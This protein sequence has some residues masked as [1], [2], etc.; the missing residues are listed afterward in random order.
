MI[1]AFGS[2]SSA[3]EYAAFLSV[4]LV[5]WLALASK[6]STGCSSR[7]T[8][9]RT[10]TV[11]SALWYESERT[12]VF[13]ACSPSASWRRRACACGPTA[14][15][16]AAGSRSCSSSFSPGTSA[17][18]AEAARAGTLTSHNAKGITNPLGAGSSL[19]G[20]IHATKV[21]IL[22]AFKSP[23]GHG[24]GTVTA[25][26]NRY[27]AS[28]TVGTEFDPGNMGIAFGVLGLAVY[29]LFAWNAIR[30]AY[31]SAVVRRDVVSLFGI[32]LLMAT[33]FQWTNGDLYSV[34]WIIWLFLGYLDVTLAKALADEATTAPVQH[35][36]AS[37]R[38]PGEP[39]R[40]TAGW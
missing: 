34:C 2:F 1:R 20:H 11:A 36:P 35:E 30:T 26:A 39:R 8:S 7:S 15:S 13:L 10:I 3:Q 33:L 40:A 17:E 22:Q 14:S 27:G 18:G 38:R 21:G 23:L 9:R 5:A 24:T 19:P 4:G 25:A 6:K 31:R 28:K 32:G 37:W 12:A 16:P 29:V